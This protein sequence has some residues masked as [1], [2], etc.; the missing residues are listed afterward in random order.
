MQTKLI[1]LALSCDPRDGEVRGEIAHLEGLEELG[2]NRPQV[3][4]LVRLAAGGLRHSNAHPERA[5]HLSRIKV[6]AIRLYVDVDAQLIDAWRDVLEPDAAVFVKIRCHGDVR[7]GL[8]VHSERRAA[9]GHGR[10]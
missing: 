2:G 6:R 7:K 1:A 5:D 10:V 3:E 4:R 9:H 8:R